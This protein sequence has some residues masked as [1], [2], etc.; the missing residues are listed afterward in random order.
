VVACHHGDA[1]GDR[2]PIPQREVWRLAM[3]KRT[4]KAFRSIVRGLPGWL[5]QEGAYML[6]LRAHALLDLAQA[7][8]RREG[9]IAAPGAELFACIVQCPALTVWPMP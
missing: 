8:N 5:L 1:A 4:T 7:G 9:S 2:L 3:S 6:K